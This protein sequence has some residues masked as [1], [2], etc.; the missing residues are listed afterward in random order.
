MTFKYPAR[1]GPGK[2]ETPQD[3]IEID[4]ATVGAAYPTGMSKPVAMA[5][6]GGGGVSG[7]GKWKLGGKIM[8][9][10]EIRGYKI[11]ESGN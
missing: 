7:L 2:I 11:V 10:V 5:D 8:W 1:T 6:V 9:K 4:L 3:I